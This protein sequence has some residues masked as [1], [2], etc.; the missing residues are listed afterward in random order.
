[1]R[2]A[3][4]REQGLAAFRWRAEAVMEAFNRGDMDAAWGHLPEDFEFHGIPEWPGSRVAAGPDEIIHYFRNEVREMLADW[5]GRVESVTEL[6]P[7][8]YL[9]HP[10]ETRTPR[11]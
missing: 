9:N 11:A 4:E 1:M 6:R 5:T 2:V 3:A 10:A 7:G 8:V